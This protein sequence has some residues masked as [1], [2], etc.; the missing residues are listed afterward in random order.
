M[1]LFRQNFSVKSFFLKSISSKIAEIC[2]HR[3]MEGIFWSF[4]TKMNVGIWI[5]CS[6]MKREASKIILGNEISCFLLF[7]FNVVLNFFPSQI[8]W[9]TKLILFDTV[10]FAKTRVEYCFLTPKWVYNFGDNNGRKVDTQNVDLP[11][12][13]GFLHARWVLTPTVKSSGK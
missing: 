5:D 1:I 12:K 13:C 3:I 7:H 4:Q 10:C 6:T 2:I 11:K 9:E 8:K